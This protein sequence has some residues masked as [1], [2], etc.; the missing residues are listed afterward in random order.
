MRPRLNAH[1]RI[2][3]ASAAR[4]GTHGGRGTWRRR[5]RRARTREVA[6]NDPNS[7]QRGPEDRLSSPTHT[8]SGCS[9]RTKRLSASIRPICSARG[10]NTNGVNC[11]LSGSTQRAVTTH[12]MHRRPP[13]AGDRGRGRAPVAGARRQILGA[14]LRNDSG[15]LVRHATKPPQR[16]SSRQGTQTSRC[17]G[18]H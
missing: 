15:L 2:Q 17:A 4:P 8:R 3:R 6:R 10:R 18:L 12:R 1:V 16:N 9:M 13:L 5:R 11:L 7:D 14:V